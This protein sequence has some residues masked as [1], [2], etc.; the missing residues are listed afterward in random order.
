MKTKFL[1]PLLVPLSL[2]FACEKQSVTEEPE[3]ISVSLAPNFIDVETDE[4]T[5]GTAT[6]DLYGINVYYSSDGT[7]Y[8]NIYAYGLFDNKEDMTISLLTGYYYKFVCSMV[9]NGKNTL[10]NS[11]GIYYYPFQHNGSLF[12]SKSN[13]FI[14]G[15][16]NCL[17]GL[18]SGSAHIAGGG[19]PTDNNFIETPQIERYYGEISNYQPITG[20]TVNIELK[21]VI[22]GAKFIITGMVDN[23]GELTVSCPGA[24]FITKNNGETESIIRSFANLRDCWLN[25]QSTMPVEVLYSMKGSEWVGKEGDLSWSQNIVFKRNYLTTITIN[26]SFPKGKIE[27]NL[28][29][30][31]I[32]DNDIDIGIGDHGFIEI[33]VNPT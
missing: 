33:V 11:S 25:D 3:Y 28:E 18:E 13:E 24:S 15:G 26:I 16:T 19:T 9:K 27:F 20:G 31:L 4:M 6:N 21:R 17:T 22:F 30:T 5:K 29:E 14:T 12:T 10:Y 2:M 23:V 7:D 8:S 32:D 1:I